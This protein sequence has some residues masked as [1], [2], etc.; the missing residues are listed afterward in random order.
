MTQPVLLL[1]ESN[2]TGT[3]R[4]FAQQARTLGIQ[5]VL[6][7]ADP[8]R[9]PYVAE[10]DVRALVVDTADD[11]AV[12]VAA[13]RLQEQAPIAGVTSSSEYYVAT[14]AATARALGLP[15]PDADAV[16]ECRDKARQRQRLHEAGVGVPRHERVHGVDGARAAAS[17][18]GY[19]VVLKP[20]QGSGSLGVRLCADAEE[21][22]AHAA[23]LT[24]AAVN[25]RGVAVPRDVLVEEYLRGAEYSV[26]VFGHTAVVVVAKHLG[27][28]PDFVELG[29]DVPAPIPADATALLRDE[30]VRA[31][32]ALGLGWGAAHVELRM[33]GDDVRVVEV[34]PRL[35]GG[36]IP[37]LVRLALGVDLV[38]CQVRTAVGASSTD[39]PSA[40]G[41]AAAIRFLTSGRPGFIADR[42]RTERAL[43]T[44]RSAPH[45]ETAVLYRA[46]DDPV[47]PSH[48]FRGRLGHVI[49]AAADSAL[50][51]AS[52]D[53]ALRELAG[54][55]RPASQGAEA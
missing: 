27:P 33:D 12:L 23:A 26:E 44:A 48:D 28:L 9:Y 35:A 3:G 17:R 13:R 10:D 46:P 6:L 16:R 36:M 50:A 15:G 2:T 22:S 52:A 55:L 40:A 14:A 20:V 1:V 21:V 31:V 38:A 32:K 4:Q 11:A 7:C 47:E 25:E 8:G 41:R 29:H 43:E 45:T 39:T 37:E 5:P 18:I 49:A 34:N 24:S 54:A 19:P 42:T 30:A 51:G 53:E